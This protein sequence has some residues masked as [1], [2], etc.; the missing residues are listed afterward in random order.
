[1]ELFLNRDWKPLGVFLFLGLAFGLGLTLGKLVQVRQPWTLD[2]LRILDPTSATNPNADVMA[3]YFRTSGSGCEIRLDYLSLNDP[4]PFFIQVRLGD[5]TLNVSGA[6]PQPAGVSLTTDTVTAT[7]VVTVEACSPRPSSLLTVRLLSQ[8]DSSVLDQIGPVAVDAPAPPAHATLSFAFYDVFSPAV[9][10]VQALRH[11]DGAHTGPRGE[12]HGLRYLLL[13]AEK[14]RIPLTLL[15]IKTLDALSALDYV[16]GLEYLQRL[17]QEGLLQMPLVTDGE[18]TSL[19]RGFSQAAAQIFGLRPAGFD[20]DALHPTAGFL[21]QAFDPGQDGLPLDARRSLLKAAIHGGEILIGGDFEQTTW[22]TPNYVDPAFAYLA[23]RPYFQFTFV[24]PG[25]APPPIMPTADPLFNDLVYTSQNHVIDSAWET[26]LML[27]PPTEDAE[28]SALR[29]N[30]RGVVASLLK[31][32]TWAQTPVPLHE[33]QE[34]GQCLLASNDMLAILDADGG[35][36]SYFFMR[37]SQGIHQVVGPTAQFFVGFSDRSLW[38]PSKGEA[39]DPE[40][41]MGAFAD[42]GNPFRHYT[43]DVLD[44]KTIRFR[45]EDGRTKTYQLGEGTLSVQI[46]GQGEALTIPLTV[47]PGARFATDWASHF[48]LVKQAGQLGWGLDHGPTVW[49]QAAGASDLH[50]DSF[51]AVQAMAS[52]PEDPNAEH[53]PALYVPFPMAI[54]HLTA[55]TDQKILFRFSSSGSVSSVGIR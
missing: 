18:P 53:P 14:N 16:G 43:P 42:A 9:T 2:D 54:V 38:N 36:L 6:G 47:E 12:R 40:Q 7:S 8:K 3:L 30:Y 15:D 22:G 11:W 17:E 4:P 33:C 49:I 39:A 41:V 34:S 52:A 44:V 46:E 5:R 26:Y 27:T 23:A 21:F 35:R 24:D 25:P 37:D 19:S 1:M 10:P 50:V 28:L 13:A 31:A 29:Q 55:S 45:S 32:G 20:Y 51:L 48:Q